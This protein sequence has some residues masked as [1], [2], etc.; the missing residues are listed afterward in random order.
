VRSARLRGRVGPAPCDA[1][2]PSE[3]DVPVSEH[4][5][6]ASPGGWRVVVAV[7]VDEAGFSL[8][9]A[10]VPDDVNRLAGSCQPG[11]P[12]ARGLWP[13]L[14]GDQGALADRAAPFLLAVE[15]ESGAVDRQGRFAPAPG[16]VVSERRVV[17]GRP[18]SD[19][20]VS[21][22]LGPGEAVEIAAG[23]AVTEHPSVLPGLVELAEVSG[24]HPVRRLGRVAELGPLLCEPPQVI[25]Q[26]LECLAGDLRPVVGGPAPDDRV[27][28]LEHRLSVAPAQGAQ[29]SCVWD[30]C[31]LVRSYDT[32]IGGSGQATDRPCVR[33][34]TGSC[35]P[36]NST[37]YGVLNCPNARSRGL[38]SFGLALLV[39]ARTVGRWSLLVPV[40]GLHV[41]L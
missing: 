20:L 9:R 32:S 19:D 3:P 15:P 24:K 37:G 7:E 39:G 40:G 10:L 11:L 14:D 23:L 12:L 21:D 8:V 34:L 17:R 1:G 6:Q 28:P 16:P 35:L 38:I 25:V 41:W 22:Y 4:P 26:R 29:L 13:V 36:R 5:A 30:I 31:L 27:E 18:V 33:R 2:P